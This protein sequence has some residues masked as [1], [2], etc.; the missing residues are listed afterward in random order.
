MNQSSNLRVHS[1]RVRPRVARQELHRGLNRAQHLTHAPVPRLPGSC[2]F[3]C[4]A[5]HPPSC[6]RPV[7]QPPCG[8]RCPANLA[9]VL[10]VAAFGALGL[11]LSGEPWCRRLRLP[12]G[13]V[14]LVPDLTVTHRKA[15]CRIFFLLIMNFISIMIN[16]GGV[17]VTPGQAFL[18]VRDP[19]TYF[20]A[21]GVE[22]GAA[23]SRRRQRADRADGPPLAEGT[24]SRVGPDLAFT[25]LAVVA[26]C[27]YRTVSAETIA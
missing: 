21:G 27:L 25:W 12:R 19:R 7:P 11:S 5:N 22:S 8:Q 14:A 13:R 6:E 16:K 18:P 24:E 23:R 2:C 17:D 10:S 9:A 1:L 4:H 20:L 15:F 3:R 26:V